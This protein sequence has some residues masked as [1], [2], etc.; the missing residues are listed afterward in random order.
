MC[1]IIIHDINKKNEFDITATEMSKYV[2][3]N[4]DILDI[5]ADT[6]AEKINVYLD[7]KHAASIRH[8][9]CCGFNIEFDFCALDVW[10]KSKHRV[11]FF[12]HNDEECR[13]E[14][15]LLDKE[16]NHIY[17]EH[18]EFEHGVLENC[19]Q[20]Q[21]IRI[22]EKYQ[23]YI[24]DIKNPGLSHI[25]KLHNQV[26]LAPTAELAQTV[27]AAAT[28]E[29]EYGDICIEGSKVTLAHH[30]SRSNNPAPCNWGDVPRLQE[31]D[32]ILISHIDLDTLGGVQKLLHTQF[33]DQKFWDAAEFIDIN[34]PQYIPEFPQDIQ[35]K[36]NAFYA[37]EEESKKESQ[38][39]SEIAD[40]T[41]VIRTYSLILKQILDKTHPEH[42]NILQAGR[43]WA[44]ENEQKISER[45]DTENEFVR[46]FKTDGVF[47]SAAYYSP[48]QEIIVPATVVYNE[49]AGSVTLAFSDGGNA[50]SA[51]E[52]VQFLWG[53]EAGGHDGIAGSPRGM[54]MSHEDYEKVTR[55]VELLES[56][57]IK[58]E[59]MIFYQYETA[60]EI[61]F[62]DAFHTE[63]HRTETGTYIHSGYIL[64]DTQNAFETNLQLQAYGRGVT[65]PVS[66]RYITA[67][68]Y[69]DAI[70]N[71]ENSVKE[72][73]EDLDTTIYEF[74][75]V[76]L[77]TLKEGLIQHFP[78]NQLAKTYI[79]ER[80]VTH[81]SSQSDIKQ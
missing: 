22:I 40:V 74:E 10:F 71:T 8:D 81:Q 30:G 20:E 67:K 21:T 26:L 70:Q 51:R 34:G 48:I 60:T 24:Y 25:R 42:Q 23:D 37:W 62:P 55:L 56:N 52:I 61:P 53:E 49:N 35:D 72:H 17:P 12:R 63:C 46:T 9:R 78:T 54:E 47:C 77:N 1:E 44:L 29:A 41:S 5:A 50:L 79:A 45:L 14:I 80:E 57:H 6:V 7:R 15:H 65:E 39:S 4:I 68:M 76:K 31:N 2:K 38:H 75:Q 58:L 18:T 11:F 43:D 16:G 19:T 66:I 33:D 28:V 32:I 69:Q 73:E 59:D 64:P 3:E 36:L 27:H 13:I